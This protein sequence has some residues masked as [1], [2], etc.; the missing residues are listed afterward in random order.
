M[1]APP[2]CDAGGLCPTDPVCG[3]P[4]EGL[5]PG[6]KWEGHANATVAQLVLGLQE[7]YNRNQPPRLDNSFPTTQN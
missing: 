4:G 7:T 1:S 2:G 6:S 5:L 3:D